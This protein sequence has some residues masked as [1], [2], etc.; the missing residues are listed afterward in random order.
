MTRFL[1]L[2]LA[3]TFA[4]PAY[5]EVPS[6]D[7]VMADRVLGDPKAPVTMIEY[8]SFT[9]SHCADFATRVLPEI[10]KQAVATG[11][12]KIIYRDFPLDGAA[13][14][15][16]A[17]ARCLPESQYYPFVKMLFARQANWAFSEDPTKALAQ[18]AALAGLSPATANACMT[19]MK[20]L[21]AL[22]NARTKAN[23]LYKIQATPTFIFNNNA[24]QVAGTK[25]LA[26]YMDI[27]NRLA[28]NPNEKIAPA[29]A[30]DH[31]KHAH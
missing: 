20:I 12:L 23:E 6:L 31:S 5:A 14:R 11:K 3:L 15:A 2:L 18:M 21:D 30:T 22:T 4:A 10:E 29:P 16:A 8:A 24:A 13:L 19:D 25:P 9:C 7:K 1:T 28:K 27:I 26:E 17:L